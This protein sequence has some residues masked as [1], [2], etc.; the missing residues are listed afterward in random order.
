MIEVRDHG[1]GFPADFLPRAFERFRRGDAARSR[2]EGG[3]G[4]GLAIVESIVRAHGGRV[5]ADNHP[6]GGARV[7]IELPGEPRS[8]SGRPQPQM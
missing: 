7:R 1:S 5:L 8:D 2:S 4:L 6:G 3:A